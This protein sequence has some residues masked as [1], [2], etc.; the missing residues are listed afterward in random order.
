MTKLNLSLS[1]PL[2]LL[3][4]KNYFCIWNSVFFTGLAN[5][6]E[7]FVAIWLVLQLTGESKWSLLLAGG[8]T[9]TRLWLSPVAIVSGAVAD[10]VSRKLLVGSMQLIA[11]AL[12]F[13]L[14]VLLFFGLLDLWHL[15]L[16]VALVGVT[17]V[18][19][20]PTAQALAGDSVPQAEIPRAMALVNAG[21]NLSMVCALPIAGI[22]YDL[23]GPAGT[24]F[25]IFLFYF[26][27]G[28][29]PLFMK[30]SNPTSTV[31]GEK[32]LLSI[33]NGFKY[34]SARQ[35]LWAALLVAVL[36][37]ITGFTFHQTLLPIF[38][39]VVI[40]ATATV[41]SLLTTV[42]AVGAFCGSLVISTI[43]RNQ[44][45]G[46]L[47]I[48]AVVT[49]HAMMLLFA[50]VSSFAVWFV[51]LG[52]AGFAWATTLINIQSLLLGQ[53]DPSYRGRIQ[54]LRTLAIYPHAL[55]SLFSGWM[56]GLIGVATAVAINGTIGII[57]ICLVA[58]IAPQLRKN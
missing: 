6:T 55:G 54:G 53:S 39:D 56:A 48:A 16:V 40:N 23:F 45:Q 3:G 22:T 27:A 12:T 44:R 25:V 57:L 51:I 28:V 30:I 21:R 36:I 20:M 42:F 47:L 31:Q 37:N 52:I 2:Q 49:W 11:A 10:K 46:L 26:I 41:A 1:G 15:F 14:V 17:R 9:A 18:F 5:H 8:I 29:S 19:E 38:A 7:A 50:I 13:I 34:V 4:T 32:L 33:V 43:S 35:I 58:L 24:F